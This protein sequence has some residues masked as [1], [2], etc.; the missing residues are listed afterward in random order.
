MLRHVVSH[1]ADGSAEEVLGQME[2]FWNYEVQGMGSHN[3]QQRSRVLDSIVR[4]SSGSAPDGIRVLELG[5]Y[6]GYTAIQLASLERNS[7]TYV[8]IEKDPLFAAIATK[9]VEHAGL[10]ESISVLIGT[11]E[12]Q[13]EN[14]PGK[15]GSPAD[16]VLLDQPSMKAGYLED[17]NRIEGAGLLR[18]GSVVICDN[19]FYPGDGGD[20]NLDGVARYLD[21]VS[22][23]TK[24]DTKVVEMQHP[25]G[26]QLADEEPPQMLLATYQ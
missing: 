3:W 14:L 20:E 6:C 11:L 19:T 4:E 12:S 7:T 22:N 13:L 17:L 18:S 15:L 10:S 16:V 24:F 23:S 26:I 2:A 8:S 1:A 21:H 9:L 5:I 25:W